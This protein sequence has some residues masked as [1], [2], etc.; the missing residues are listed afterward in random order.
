MQNLVGK[1]VVVETFEI[2][3][4]GTLVELGEQEAHLQTDI[5]WIVIPIERITD[6]REKED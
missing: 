3:Y 2:T 6:I 5:G 1:T 4:T